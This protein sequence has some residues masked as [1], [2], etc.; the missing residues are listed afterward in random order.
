MFANENVT[1][2]LFDEWGMS[3]L[4]KF[5]SGLHDVEGM[6]LMAVPCFK[7]ARRKSPNGD[8]GNILSEKLAKLVILAIEMTFLSYL[9]INRILCVICCLSAALGVDMLGN[10]EWVI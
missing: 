8:L 9:Q 7:L 6:L 5:T 4:N 10:T 1:T 3:V 2:I